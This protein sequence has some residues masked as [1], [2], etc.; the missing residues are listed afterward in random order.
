MLLKVCVWVFLGV[1]VVFGAVG[2]HTY[3]KFNALASNPKRM[4]YEIRSETPARFAE[5]LDSGLWRPVLPDAGERS[6]PEQAMLDALGWDRN[7]RSV[8]RLY[9]TDTRRP[10][11]YR[12]YKDDLVTLGML[13]ELLFETGSERVIVVSDDF[14]KARIHLHHNLVV[15]YDTSEHGVRGRLLRRNGG[16]GAE[17][18]QK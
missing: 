11:F 5:Y 1:I 7:L 10:S 9:T 18:F 13:Q 2:V 17:D 4:P 16:E 8:I 3:I 6:N 15:F 12:W 14:A